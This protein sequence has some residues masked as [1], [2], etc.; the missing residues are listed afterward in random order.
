MSQPPIQ[1]W[2]DATLALRLWQERKLPPPASEPQA[3]EPQA[4]GSASEPP[5]SSS[6]QIGATRFL[7]DASES[8]SEAPTFSSMPP[9]E[10][11]AFETQASAGPTQYYALNSFSDA[12]PTSSGASSSVATGDWVKVSSAVDTRWDHASC[13]DIR[14][15][16]SLAGPPPD[17]GS[18]SYA[19]TQDR[20]VY[21]YQPPATQPP[22][23]PPPAG[24]NA[25][26]N[27]FYGVNSGRR[28]II[29]AVPAGSGSS[30]A[31][32]GLIVPRKCF[33]WR[34]QVSVF[35]FLPDNSRSQGG[36]GFNP[37]LRRGGAGGGEQI[38]PNIKNNKP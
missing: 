23:T 27:E 14:S 17:D 21:D 15:A 20:L 30:N 29:P 26:N 4:S 12:M 2:P 24:S 37:V 10:P 1:S 35:F 34:R 6:W 9:S 11:Q 19:G 38:Q 16:H 13:S 32:G 3:L 25:L 5:G 33:E 28:V 22:A 31:L 8:A 18:T 7:L 36:R